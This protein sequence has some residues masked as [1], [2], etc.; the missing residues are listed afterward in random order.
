MGLVLQKQLLPFVS[1]PFMSEQVLCL[2]DR[3]AVSGDISNDL[4]GAQIL[5]LRGQPIYLHFSWRE[6]VVVKF[7]KKGSGFSQMMP[8]CMLES[9]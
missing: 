2:L 4:H 7:L 6:R 9:G 8:I 1:G 5:S 3:A